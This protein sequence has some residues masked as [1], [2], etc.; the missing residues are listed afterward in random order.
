MRSTTNLATRTDTSDAAY[1]A[2]PS[3]AAARVLQGGGSVSGS[4]RKSVNSSLTMRRAW[5]IM[6]LTL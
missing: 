4:A 5:L 6:R 3:G 2:A 1:V